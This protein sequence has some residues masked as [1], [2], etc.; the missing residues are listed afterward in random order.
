MAFCLPV[1][2]KVFQRYTSQT[3]LNHSKH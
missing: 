2:S 3:Y 1:I